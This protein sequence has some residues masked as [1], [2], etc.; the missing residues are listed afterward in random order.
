MTS[1]RSQALRAIGLVASLEGC[2]RPLT[3]Y[4]PVEMPT[5]Q[6]LFSRL[7]SG[8]EQALEELIGRHGAAIFSCLRRLLHSY[9]SAEDAFQ[10]TWL[11]VARNCTKLRA[12]I[13]PRAW[14]FRVALNAARDHSRRERAARRGGQTQQLPIDGL[15]IAA[16]ASAIEQSDL[17][18]LQ[19]A[20]QSLPPKLREPVCLH[21]FDGLTFEEIATVLRR[22]VGTVKSRVA[23]A[24]RK[25]QKELV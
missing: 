3:L 2:S 10:E 7:R 18:A 15:E 8:D 23:R 14:L 16:P 25:M 6:D 9:E 1:M 24:L 22:P 11:H 19:R 17:I 4:H 20:V 12:G 13:P 21:Y 5:D